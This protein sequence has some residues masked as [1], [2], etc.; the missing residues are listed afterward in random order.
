MIEMLSNQVLEH[1]QSFFLPYTGCLQ[2]LCLSEIKKV[3]VNDSFRQH[4]FY[5]FM[6]TSTLKFACLI[7]QQL[8]PQFFEL[9]QEKFDFLKF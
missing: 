5:V 1:H 9:R 3:V 2:V 8:S 4:L 6:C 7:L